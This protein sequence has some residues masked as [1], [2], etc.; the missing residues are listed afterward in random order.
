MIKGLVQSCSAPVIPPPGTEP[1]RP[2]SVEGVLLPPGYYLLHV[3][4]GGVGSSRVAVT[5]YFS[6]S[7]AEPFP[8]PSP[9]RCPCYDQPLAGPASGGGCRIWDVRCHYETIR[10]EIER[11]IQE[12]IAQAIEKQLE[13][14][15]GGSTALAPLAMGLVLLRRSRRKK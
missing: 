6:G 1:G 12:A 2:P 7:A 9:V 10:A 15:C 3:D 11:R 4:Q 14:M 5:A 13:E 8:W